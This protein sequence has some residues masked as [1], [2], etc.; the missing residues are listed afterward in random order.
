MQRIFNKKLW[1]LALP[2]AVFMAGCNGDDDGGGGDT[3]APTVSSTNPLD[4]ATGMVTNQ[5][6]TATFSE[7]I[8]PSSCTPTTFTLKQGVLAVPGTVACVNR[9]ATFDPTG[10]LAA[11]ALYTAKITTGVTD[12]AGNALAVEKTWTFT[13]GTAADTT[14]PTL[15]STS[16]ASGAT[17]AAF[18]GIITATFSEAMDPATITPTTFTLEETVAGTPVTGT[19]SSLGGGAIFDPTGSLAA[20]REY[21]ATITTG[22]KDLAGNAFA[23][24]TWNFT[25]GTTAAAGPAPVLLGTAGDFVILSK[26]GISTVPTSAITGNI[27]VSPIDE[28]AIT[29]FSK[30]LDGSGEFSTSAQVTGNIYAADYAVPTPSYMTTAVSD[31]ELAYVDARD[32]SNPDFTELGAGDISGMTLAP[33][34]YKW[35][36]G[37]GISAVGVTL[38]G[39]ENDVWIFQI[40]GDLTVANAA[41][42]TLGGAAQAK[43]IFWQTFGVAE[44]GTTAQFEGIILSQT[45]INLATDAVVNGR[46][47]AQTAVTLDSN[48]V[49]AP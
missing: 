34:L 5:I 10:N 41:I 18:N 28:T 1:L 24:T 43:N 13:T 26:S 16:P 9:T 38:S 39:A 30:T 22:V 37:V 21:T 8:A 46:L 12:L 14:A 2:L 20:S 48:T 3:T 32:R 44:I 4:T 42:V 47:L 29:G 27:G 36:T 49:S 19:V 45:A 33:G 7:A 23:G 25:T 15:S 40:A 35:G 11:S 31:M 17:G 6:I